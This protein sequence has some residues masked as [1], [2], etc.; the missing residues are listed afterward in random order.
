MLRMKKTGVTMAI[1]ARLISSWVSRFPRSS[2]LVRVTVCVRGRTA[3]AKICMKGGSWVS[4]KKVPLRRN[5]GV[6]KR[7]P[8]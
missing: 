6:M 8:G 7:K 3:F 2:A 5:I 4:G 1:Q